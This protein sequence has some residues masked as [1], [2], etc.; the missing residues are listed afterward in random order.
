MICTN[1][2]FHYSVWS[3]Q[4]LF[5]YKLWNG[6]H[7]LI[8]WFNVSWTLS[9]LDVVNV[10][11]VYFSCDFM[12]SSLI[13]LY[14]DVLVLIV[15]QFVITWGLVLLR[16]LSVC[17]NIC[18]NNWFWFSPIAV[19]GWYVNVSN[20]RYQTFHGVRLL[21]LTLLFPHFCVTCHLV[22]WYSLCLF[23][24][25]MVVSVVDCAKCTCSSVVL[26]CVHC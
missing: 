8:C 20:S 10:L 16:C 26:T 22:D 21:I 4:L 9:F 13:C 23:H 15:V 5:S 19:V 14:S 7:Q 6:W 24:S 11:Q 1:C 12:W 25:M 17:Y 2:T 18:D 3:F